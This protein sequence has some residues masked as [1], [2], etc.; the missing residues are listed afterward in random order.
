MKVTNYI[1]GVLFLIM[2]WGVQACSFLEIEPSKEFERDD[3]YAD[4]TQA[5]MALA[6][7]YAKLH[8]QYKEHLSIWLNAGTDELLH[9]KQASSTRGSEISKFTYNAFDENVRKMWTQSYDLIARANDFIYNLEGRDTI[10]K[11]EPELRYGMIGEALTLR[12]MSYLNLVRM[13]EYVPLRIDPFVDIA[14]QE[15]DLHLKVAAPEETYDQIITDLEAAIDLLPESPAQYGRISKAAAQGLLART[16][17]SLTGVRMN[18]GNVGMEECY[19]RVVSHCDGV[20]N[21]GKH[22]LL[23]LYEDVFL[24]EIQQVQDDREVIWEV[25]YQYTTERDLGGY[26]GNYNGARVKGAVNTDPEGNPHVYITP[27]LNQVYGAEYEGTPM[28]NPDTRHGWNV[29]PYNTNYTN[30]EYNFPAVDITNKLRWYAGKWKR[31]MRVHE[32]DDEDGNPIY[33]A[34]KLETGSINKWRTSINFPLLRYSDI[35]LMKAEAMNALY[36]PIMNATAPINE[37]RARA[38]VGS[39]EELL[40]ASGEG[41]SQESL[42]KAIQ[43]ERMRELCFEGHR[44]FDLVRWGLLESNMKALNE[45]IL[46]YPDYDPSKDVFLTY[47]GNNVAERHVVFPLPNDEITLNPKLTQHPLWR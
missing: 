21:G 28:D 7:V 31:V 20:I 8:E 25:M 18:G 19:K 40:I 1:S 15:E 41:V 6:G 37:V 14:Q 45:T 42:Q 30:G 24:K 46:N 9:A 17:L 38:G 43:D 29:T 26:I 2:L 10:S 36:G 34:A 12:A 27:H 35:L 44:R 4:A 22:S 23:E 3:Y 47:P 5:Q 32:G 11:M 33:K 39:I 13:Y 16:Y